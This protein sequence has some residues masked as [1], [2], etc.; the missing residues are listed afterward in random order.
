MLIHKVYGRAILT[1]SIYSNTSATES[2]LV[3]R[4]AKTL[5]LKSYM[6]ASNYLSLEKKILE[7]VRTRSPLM[8][9]AWTFQEEMLSS[10]ILSLL[11]DHGILWNCS[12]SECPENS[13]EVRPS[14]SK[15]NENGMA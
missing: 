13:T 8:E 11:S 9:H 12:K 3:R 2:F 14:Y 4:E 15:N 7:D 1:W 6:L 10:R 5:R